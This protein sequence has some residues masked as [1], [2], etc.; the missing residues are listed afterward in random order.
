MKSS[1]SNIGHKGA[2]HFAV[3]MSGDRNI[4]NDCVL[5]SNTHELSAGWGNCDANIN[6]EIGLKE[7]PFAANSGILRKMTQSSHMTVLT[8][9]CEICGW[10]LDPD[11]YCEGCE[12]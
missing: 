1:P 6:G 2:T 7:I 5:E 4:E 10:D 11:G 9:D 3:S 12:E 8:Q